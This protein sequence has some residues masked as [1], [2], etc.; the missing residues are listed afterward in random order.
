[1]L[2]PV[3]RS[4]K[5][6]IKKPLF[7]GPLPSHARGGSLTEVFDASYASFKSTSLKLTGVVCNSWRLDRSSGKLECLPPSEEERAAEVEFLDEQKRIAAEA[8]AQ[9]EQEVDMTG[10]GLTGRSSIS[11]CYC[12]CRCLLLEATAIDIGS[13]KTSSCSPI[14]F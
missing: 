7:L 8:Q 14:F 1:M 12:R 4:A 9:A 10:D 13:S 11:Y 2:E 5:K 6:A 3:D